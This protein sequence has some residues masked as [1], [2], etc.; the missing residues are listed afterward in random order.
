MS[1]KKFWI[2]VLCVAFLSPVSPVSTFIF[3]ESFG[4]YT[5]Y[6]IHQQDLK[7]D[8]QRIQEQSVWEDKH[9]ERMEIMQKEFQKHENKN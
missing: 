3:V 6:R 4:A 2:I 8:A 1:R 5:A 7:N 9:N